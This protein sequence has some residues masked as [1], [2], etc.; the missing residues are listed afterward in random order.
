M[1]LYERTELAGEPN[2]WYIEDYVK[3]ST[4][5]NKNL[6]EQ[7]KNPEEAWLKL[8]FSAELSASDITKLDAIIDDSL[9]K[10]TVK[11]DSNKI[12]SEIFEAIGDDA[13]QLN[14]MTI[15]FN[16]DPFLLVALNNRNYAMARVIVQGSK[17][18][19]NITEADETM[20]L[21]IIPDSKF[22]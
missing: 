1:W 9:D 10:A 22:E 20:I 11:K 15:A 19:G 8:W 21:G 3:S 16:A 4:M 6:L 13:A 18:K 5:S 14:R 2:H 12:M 17:T 7:S